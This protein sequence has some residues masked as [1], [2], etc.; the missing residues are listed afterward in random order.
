[1]SP[2]A[3]A[4]QRRVEDEIGREHLDAR[5][6]NQH[7]RADRT[8]HALRDFNSHPVRICACACVV[9]LVF[10]AE[11]DETG[12]DAR[13][14]REREEEGED[15]VEPPEIALLSTC[16][17]VCWWWR[18]GKGGYVDAER[19]ASEELVER[20]RSYERLEVGARG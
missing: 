10:A 3:R 1:M 4:P 6:V 20:Y 9:A 15:R 7:A 16:T 12:E 18:C 11:H 8:Q 13:G 14:C 2:L 17:C 19:E 5:G